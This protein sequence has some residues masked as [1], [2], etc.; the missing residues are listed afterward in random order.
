MLHKSYSSFHN[1]NNDAMSD[2]ASRITDTN[3][4]NKHSSY[5][6][7]S[8][9]D[10]G[11]V[12]NAADQ[13]HQ[14]FQGKHKATF[15]RLLVGFG[16]VA[17]V[18]AFGL[19]INHLDA[20]ENIRHEMELV[21]APVV[22][23][24]SDNNVI[25]T[26]TA[27][28]NNKSYPASGRK[29]N[30]DSDCT[31]GDPRSRGCWLGQCKICVPW[32]ENCYYTENDLDVHVRY[33]LSEPSLRGK[34]PIDLLNVDNTRV[35]GMG[36]MAKCNRF[37]SY[38]RYDGIVGSGTY[39]D[40]LLSGGVELQPNLPWTFWD[41]FGPPNYNDYIRRN[42]RDCHP[43]QP[44]CRLYCGMYGGRQMHIL[45]ENLEY[46]RERNIVQTG[47]YEQVYGTSTYTFTHQWLRL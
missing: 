34:G 32:T 42:P 23:T 13:E 46:N 29:C 8:H 27:I 28:V 38:L 30:R 4:S 20:K 17:F 2:E 10:S 26:S 22:N 36:S 7:I 5:Q 43:N 45:Y 6:S 12:S 35:S 24:A 11:L 40:G 41:D 39:C 47:T 18:G 44:G 15:R 21:E 37:V 31:N 14:G 9:D 19:A 3:I 1:I 25:V 16:T 33:D